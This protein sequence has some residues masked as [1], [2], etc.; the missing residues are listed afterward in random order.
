MENQK[1]C[2]KHTCKE[3][4]TVKKVAI[5]VAQENQRRSKKM[6]VQILVLEAE[7][8]GPSDAMWKTEIG[9]QNGSVEGQI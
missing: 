8:T 2:D 5:H 7:S 9:A 6:K 4:S 3:M 1:K